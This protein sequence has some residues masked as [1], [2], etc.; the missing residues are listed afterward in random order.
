[1]S[2]WRGLENQEKFGNSQAAAAEHVF[3]E[4][5]DGDQDLREE[6]SETTAVIIECTDGENCGH[7]GLEDLCN[8]RDYGVE[9]RRC[10]GSIAARE[11]MRT[12]SLPM[13]LQTEPMIV[14]GLW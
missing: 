14:K 8:G 3:E 11:S 12:Y 2:R 7:E 10:S 9:S 13:A 5:D 6:S 4:L 1:V